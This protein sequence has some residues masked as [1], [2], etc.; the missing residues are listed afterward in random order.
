MQSETAFRPDEIPN[1]TVR[2]DSLQSSRLLGIL[3]NSLN[4]RYVTDDDPT[5]DT[6][7]FCFG[8]FIKENLFHLWKSK[9]IIE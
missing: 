1:A 6:I 8:L 5:E 2:P 7:F 9:W 4:F 3:P